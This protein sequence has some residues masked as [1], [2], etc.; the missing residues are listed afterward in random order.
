MGPAKLPRRLALRIW[1]IEP[2]AVSKTRSGHGQ[3]VNYLRWSEGNRLISCSRNRTDITVGEIRIWDIESEQCSGILSSQVSEILT[4]DVSPNGTGVSAGSSDGT[5]SSWNLPSNSSVFEKSAHSRAVASLRYAPDGSLFATSARD[6]KIS[7]WDAETGERIK[8]T[9]GRPIEFGVM[10]I[11]SL[12]WSPNGERIVL[13]Y[14]DSS[15]EI[16]DS[17]T[18]ELIQTLRDH[19]ISVQTV[20]WSHDGKRIASGSNNATIIIWSEDTDLDGF[21]DNNDLFPD[22]DNEWKDTDGDGIGD[23]SD[24]FPENPLEW[25]DRDRDGYGDNSD[26]F[27]DDPG[28]WKDRDGDGLG[29]NS[30]IAPGMHNTLLYTIIF[31]SIAIPS[32]SFAGYKTRKKVKER[33]KYLEDLRNWSVGLGYPGDREMEKGTIKALST[34]F[35]LRKRLADYTPIVDLEQE[36]SK[37][38]DNLQGAVKIY[39]N[40]IDMNTRGKKEAKERKEKIQKHLRILTEEI[41]QLDVLEKKREE[42]MNSLDQKGKRIISSFPR[43]T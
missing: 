5:V 12:D 42:H 29:D 27:P 16:R 7:V 22:N 36:I 34:V 8:T 40:L 33:R 9:E 32:L 10:G 25:S 24:V 11:L 35:S 23:N 39:Q 30:D 4:L 28:D 19:V 31:L 20:D 21:A 2:G 43:F 13:S 3:S 18:L 37:M 26:L 6:N 15:I 17:R 41:K 38:V 14:A 1:D